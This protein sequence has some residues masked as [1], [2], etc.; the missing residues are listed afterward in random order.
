MRV[1]LNRSLSTS[2][3][4]GFQFTFG[5]F[6]IA[7][8]LCL[9]PASGHNTSLT[10]LCLLVSFCHGQLVRCVRPP[11]TNDNGDG[12]QQHLISILHCVLSYVHR[13]FVVVLSPTP[14]F[15]TMSITINGAGYR[16]SSIFSISKTDIVFNR[17]CELVEGDFSVFL[18]NLDQSLIPGDFTWVG[19]SLVRAITPITKRGNELWLK[20]GTGS[21]NL[22]IS[23]DDFEMAHL[24]SSC[25]TN[26]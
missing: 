16:W 14:P 18:D 12:I 11:N 15:F 26:S 21:I 6:Q 13:Q 22:V 25:L 10:C 2:F 1:E 7:K 20:Y 19:Q 3:T 8:D 24:P 23:L 4:L 9:C 17:G 5:S